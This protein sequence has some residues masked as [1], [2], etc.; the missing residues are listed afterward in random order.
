MVPWVNRDDDSGVPVA[1]LVSLAGAVA[2]ILFGVIVFA[3]SLGL[4]G[5]ETLLAQIR[6]EGTITI[7][8]RAGVTTYYEGEDGPVG[9]EHDLAMAFAHHLGVEARFEAEDTVP[10]LLAGLAQGH[11][12][13]GAASLSTDVQLPDPLR[14]GPVYGDVR[15]QLV[16]HRDGPVPRPSGRV[17]NAR[18]ADAPV[19]VIVEGSHE[20]RLPDMKRSAPSLDWSALY[21]PTTEDL[22]G[23]V[24]ARELD[25]TVGESTMVAVHRRSFPDLV[26]PFEIAEANHLSWAL[27]AKAHALRAELARWFAMEATQELIAQLEE[28]YYGHMPDF[29]YVDFA[30]FERRVQSRLPRYRPHFEAAAAETALSWELLAAL[31][32][33]ESHWRPRARSATGVRGMMMLTLATARDLGVK[34]RLDPVQ[35]IHGG[36]QY[37]AKLIARIPES[38]RG[39]DRLW[40]ALAA[41]NVGFG[42][43]MDARTLALRQGLNPDVW[44]D[45]KRTLPLLAQKAY[46]RTVPHGYAR[47]H[48][49][50]RYVQHVRHYLDILERLEG[51]DI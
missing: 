6:R 44:T 46:Y 34:N 2:A 16:C 39:E 5:P 12:Q 4:I 17:A 51:Q 3:R 7:L 29:D 8:T 18:S 49:P 42:H 33:Q 14:F 25:C 45:V 31:S 30:R 37:L 48:E 22:V 21:G 24:A 9:F 19:N 41:Y 13:V 32:Y 38:V 26:V 43:L 47:G 23:R 27:P 28:R 36:A 35:S 10:E 1:R 50:V 40:F 20:Q 15:Y 11:G